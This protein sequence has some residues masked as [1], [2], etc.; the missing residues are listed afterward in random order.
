MRPPSPFFAEPEPQ[1]W[2][3]ARGVILQT[4]GLAV[5]NAFAMTSDGRLVAYCTRPQLL[6]LWDTERRRKEVLVKMEFEPWI[7]RFSNDDRY[8]V[9]AGSD[10][11]S[12][13]RVFS[14]ESKQWVGRSDS[15]LAVM[16]VMFSPD[17][18]SILSSDM[19]TG[20]VSKWDIQLETPSP[21]PPPQAGA[22]PKLWEGSFHPPEDRVTRLA[23]FPCSQV[24]L[25]VPRPGVSACA[26]ARATKAS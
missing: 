20:V 24:S 26:G 2:D 10:G 9:C 11:A 6:C 1:I 8:I 7:L 14:M 22:R 12:H 4:L 23:V 19:W 3:V 16:D 15:A 25:K 13:F 5:R 17:D 18:K 21:G